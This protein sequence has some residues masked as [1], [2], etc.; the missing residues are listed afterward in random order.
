VQQTS[1]TRQTPQRQPHCPSPHTPRQ[2]LLKVF[3]RPAPR[4]TPSS[5]LTVERPR[6]STAR[7]LDPRRRPSSETAQPAQPAQPDSLALDPLVVP[8]VVK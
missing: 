1:D 8:C 4:A 7:P 6:P 5:D 2:Q 3:F